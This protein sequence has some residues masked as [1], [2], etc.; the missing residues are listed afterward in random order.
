[1]ADS[2]SLLGQTISHYRITEKL[3][4]GGMGVVYKAEDIRL[5][6]FV[7]LKFLPDDV[8]KDPQA[9]ARFQREA[10]A[11]SALN[12]PNICTIHDI[13][14]QDGKAFIA[15]EFLDGQTLKHFISGQSLEL[16]RLLDISIDVADALDAAHAQGIVHRDIKPANIFITK[17]GHAKIL[18]FGLAKV[19]GMKVSAGGDTAQAT[20]GSDSEQLT[21]PGSALGTVSYMSPEQVLGKQ[22]D[23]RTDLFSFGV[24]LY[25]MATGFLPFRG[26]SSGAIFN[27][28]LNKTPVAVIR[29]NSNTPIELEQ[30][31]NKAM[32]KDRDLRYQS[33][34]EMRADL[35]RL[36]RDTASGKH[37]HSDREISAAS[38]S[39]SATNAAQVAMPSG[40]SLTASAAVAQHSSGS[41]AIATV[42]KEHKLGAAAIAAIVLVLIVGTGFG[43]RSFFVHSAPRPFAQFSITQA[44]NSGT[45]TLTAISPDGKYLLFTKRENGLESL[46]LRNVPTSSDTQVVAPSPNP[47]AT[48]SF[49][50]DGNYLYFR[51]A[52][53]K[54]GL[55]DLLFRSPVLG[56]TPKMLVRDIDAHPVISADGQRMI[57]I[58]CSN[59][60]PDKC[61]WLSANSDGSGEQLLLV[62]NSNDGMPQHLSW[63]PDGKRLAFSLAFGSPQQ[64][65]T[66]S[67]FDVGKNQEAPVI[68][69]P[70]KRITDVEWLPDGRGVVILYLGK[71][72][73]FQRGQIGYVSYPDGKFEPLTNDTNNYTTLGLARDGKTLATIQAQPVGELDVLPAAGGP[74]GPPVPGVAKQLQ[75]ARS[76]AWLTDSEFL[77]VLPD[78]ILRVSSDGSKQTELFSDT[79][80]SLGNIVVCKGGSSIVFR[81]R[82]HEG[83][84]AGRIWRMDPDGSNL[85]RLT[86]GEIDVGP[87]CSQ[88]GKWLYYFDGK[89]SHPM[90]VSL[91]GGTPEVLPPAAV[92][93]SSARGFGA[94]SPDDKMLAVFGTVVDKATNTYANKFAFYNTDSLNAPAAVLTANPRV[95]A[96]N[97]GMRFTPDGKALAY[98]IRSENNVDNIWVQ[99][100]DGKPGRQITQFQSDQIPGFGW[101]PDGKKLMV[102][103]GHTESDVILLIDTSK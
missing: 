7:A 73:N 78:R 91:D 30:L 27:E 65:Q 22:L 76:V 72:T 29:L 26:E 43:L 66:L 68:T 3:G 46:W 64:N 61:R 9:L 49:S 57:Y 2:S 67:T 45:A 28:I 14:E 12:H 69:F 19:S 62:R 21:S 15:M 20:L 5:H 84:D 16:D 97:G 80:A 96:L 86:N 51:Q 34:A 44:T 35:K 70:D 53:D 6:R 59:P 56:G 74:A 17:R 60:E 100:L 36:K 38:A 25:E 79:S 4:G 85:T 99:P 37:H 54:T 102:G 94:I 92:P 11:A 75:Q 52:G 77:I 31:I 42:A 90:R 32:E 93:N 98:V 1:M 103:R 24:L 95:T 83:S 18:D 50:P 48:L 89:D 71:G 23:A 47:F 63:S 101:S 41:S 55:Y 81:M 33:A 8:A 10:Q 88:D 39:L 87:L 82:G 13:G 58:R 40:A